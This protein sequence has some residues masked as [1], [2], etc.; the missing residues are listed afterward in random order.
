MVVTSKTGLLA[1]T[2]KKLIRTQDNS[3]SLKVV[4]TSAP[5]VLKPFAGLY[6][7]FPYGCSLLC[8]HPADSEARE[9]LRRAK[10]TWAN[11]G[12]NLLLSDEVEAIRAS[13]GQLHV[14]ITS[15]LPIGSVPEE[16]F[17]RYTETD[18]RPLTPAPTLVSAHTRASGSRR[19]VTPDPMLNTDV[20]E[21]TQ[22]ILDLRRSHSQETLSWCAG[23]HHE[24]PSIT[25]ALMPEERKSSGATYRSTDTPETP[26][27]R[28]GR[29]SKPASPVKAAANSN[30]T[31]PE[32]TYLKVAEGDDDDDN[33][34]CEG[35]EDEESI[36]RRRGKKRRRRSRDASRGPPAFQS[37]IDP[38]TL[39]ATIGPESH[40]PSARPSLVPND[41]S[42]AEN[43][44]TLEVPVITARSTT[45][46][47]S[48]D[49]N[50]FLDHDI[51]K[52]LRRELDEEVIGNEFNIKVRLPCI[53]FVS[54]SKIL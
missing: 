8:N 25:V 51:L 26:R 50:S 46:P 27:K 13:L 29:R 32:K 30:D 19:C 49:I 53:C 43:G 16:L 2:T 11:E 28:P 4:A 22:L 7:P 36:I 39:V 34:E 45:R 44:I 37:S 21:K 14:K 42:L 3:V 38:E 20:R 12:K 40:N 17:R 47:S 33:S 48:L 5:Y 24:I 1:S 18:S 15:D 9:L 35:D 23:L 41:A 54:L 31:K 52:L 6:N 10:D